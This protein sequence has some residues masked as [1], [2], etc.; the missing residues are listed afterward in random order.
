MTLHGL[1]TAKGVKG[2]LKPSPPGRGIQG[3]SVWSLHVPQGICHWWL[4]ATKTHNSHAAP[5]RAS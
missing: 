2:Y 3:H 1:A 5:A 4:E